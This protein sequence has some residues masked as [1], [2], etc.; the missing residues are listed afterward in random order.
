MARFAAQVRSKG[1]LKHMSSE[2]LLSAVLDALGLTPESRANVKAG[3]GMK[4]ALASSV[5][6]GTPDDQKRF[7][8]AMAHLR[9]MFKDRGGPRRNNK[10]P[11]V[12][13]VNPVP[14]STPPAASLSE[15]TTLVTQ[16]S[17]TVA[18]N[19]VRMLGG[20]RRARGGRH[21]QNASSKR[22]PGGGQGKQPR[23][24]G[25]AGR[26]QQQQGGV[27]KEKVV[28]ERAQIPA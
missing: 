25:G 6:V 13:Q 17:T 7:N 10:L 9:E 12:A 18:D 26:Q 21:N 5:V 11:T 14:A 19:V 24:E 27:P 22:G 3:L 2:Y 16:L 4:I 23:Q 8:A 20:K 1:V 15:L 28:C